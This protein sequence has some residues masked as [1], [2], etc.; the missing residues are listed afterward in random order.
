MQYYYHFYLE[1]IIPPLSTVR[2]NEMKNRTSEM[3]SGCEDNVRPLQAKE[4]NE[5]QSDRPCGIWH[6]LVEQYHV[7]NK[8]FSLLNRY[9]HAKKSFRN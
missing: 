4:L 1:N 3:R 2:I 6:K 8:K 9:I 5:T 7:K